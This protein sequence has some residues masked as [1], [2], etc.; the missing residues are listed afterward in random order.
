MGGN[1]LEIDGIPVAGESTI[2]GEY[3][4]LYARMADLVRTGTSDADLA[5]MIHVAD[6]MTMGRRVVTEPFDF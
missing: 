6:A 1:V 4:A 5:P 3:P 2:M